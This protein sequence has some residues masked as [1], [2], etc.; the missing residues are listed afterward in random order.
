MSA[1]SN[2]GARLLSLEGELISELEDL[3]VVGSPAPGCPFFAVVPSG[4]G[5]QI[6]PGPVLLE[7]EEGTRYAAQIE[8]ADSHAKSPLAEVRVSGVLGAPE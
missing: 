4:S 1:M 7:T 2:G 5:R 6:Q 3:D 8:R